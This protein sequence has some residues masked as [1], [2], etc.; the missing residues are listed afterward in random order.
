MFWV[1]C[2]GWNMALAGDIFLHRFD[3]LL[4]KNINIEFR[5]HKDSAKLAMDKCRKWIDSG[6]NVMIFP[7]VFLVFKERY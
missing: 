7:E 4:E 6:A 5:G 1:P 2:V 3:F